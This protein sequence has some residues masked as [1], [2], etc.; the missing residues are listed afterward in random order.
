MTSSL[1]ISQHFLKKAPVNPSGPGGLVPRYLLDH[2]MHLI[3]GE[4]LTETLQVWVIKTQLLPIKI[5]PPDISSTK[6][7]IEMV[8]DNFLLS[9]VVSDPPIIMS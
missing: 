3:L 8:M 5:M 9:F 4:R 2:P 6:D 7:R 1:I